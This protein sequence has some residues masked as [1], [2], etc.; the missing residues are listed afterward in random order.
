VTFLTSALAIG[1][2]E[3]QWVTLIPGIRDRGFDVQLVTLVGEGP[4]FEQLRSSGIEVTCVAMRRRTDLR[5]IVRAFRATDDETD[6]IVSQSVNAQAVATLL[7]KVKRVPHVTIDHG[8]PGITFRPHQQ[9]LVRA[10]ARTA[11]LLIAV[12]PAQVERLTRLGFRRDRIAVIPN[13]V[14]TINPTED[15]RDTRRRMG[16]AADDFVALL[17]ADLRPAKQA[18]LFVDA[19]TRA[20]ALNAR[21]KGFVA[22]SGPER[23]RVEAA[24]ARSA[25]SVSMLGPRLDVPNLMNAADVVCLSSATEGSPMVLLEAMSLGK[26]VVATAVGGVTLLVAGE[27]TGILVPPQDT[28]AFADAILRLANDRELADRLGAAGRARQQERF[29]AKS[30]I[31]AYAKEFDKVIER[32]ARSRRS[33]G[34]ADES[35]RVNGEHRESS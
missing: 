14:S 5:G 22:G 2:A 15:E 24:V 21:V 3:R 1:G 28:A 17:V 10:V 12:S 16:S 29:D 8:G 32:S 27:E 6:L 31:D 34:R 33:R 4:F 13:G 20:H 19:V 18:H 11:D 35:A 23:M 26:P 9:A 30:M 25:G 7:A